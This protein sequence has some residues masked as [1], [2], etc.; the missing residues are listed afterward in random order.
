[1]S[2]ILII[3][4]VLKD[5]YLKLDDGPQ[6]DFETDE[7]GI[8][9]LDL[10]FNGAAHTFY[11]RTSVYGGAAVSLAT[12]SRLGVDAGILNS[13]T[14]FKNGELVWLDE[15]S[16]YR[17]IFCREGEI[18]YFVP[19]KRKMTDWSMP[20]GTPEWILVDRSTSISAKLVDE[21]KNFLKFSPETKLAVHAEKK[22]TPVG[23]RLADM[24]DVLF[25]ED[26]PAVHTEEKIVD[27]VELDQPNTQLVC[28]ISPRKI[29]LGEAEESWN[30]SRTDMLT[31][32]TVYSTI[33]ATVLG[34][35]S[36]GGSPENAVLWARLN[37]EQSTLEG[38][39]TAR[40]LKELAKAELEK[41]TN[42]KLIAQSIMERGRGVLAADQSSKTL[43]ERMLKAG[44]A[45]TAEKRRAFMEILLTTP[46]LKDYASGVIIS[47]EVAKQKTSQGRSFLEHLVYRGLIPGIKV[48]LGLVKLS[49]TGET[50]TL[51]LNGLAERLRNYYD[52][53]FRFAK[54]RAKFEITKDWP[55]FIAINKNAEQ[56]A[57]FA[58]E[59]QLA[60]LVPVVESDIVMD[61]DFTI[62]RGVEVCD[63]VLNSIFA[64]LGERRVD[65][66]GCI[67]KTNMV[68]SGKDAVVPANANEIGI[69]TAAVLRHAT[70]K[71]LAGVLLLSGGQDPKTAT[72]NL[73]AVCQNGPFPWPV[74]FAFGRA[75]QDPVLLT[76]KG[77]PENVKAAQAALKRHLQDNADALRYLRK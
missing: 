18:T 22:M 31:H 49:E 2:K 76:W 68:T 47:D 4:N 34:V 73:V 5:V 26:E 12:L 1:M 17:Y 20:N 52:R 43:S 72:K 65:L 19:G 66:G 64:R 15:P 44:V 63:R 42:L 29:S 27:K 59:C 61:G 40:R 6:N 33:V 45:A 21:I 28:H 38:T 54:W 51:G 10:A 35:L 69:A 60:G 25:L 70:P 7:N 62:E 46:E 67:L 77:K 48:D 53:G 32:L 39:L 71:Y 11:H 8:K 41:R 57:S 14:E 23:Q 13:K 36:V 74:T 3:G 24:A 55:T 37:A 16:D 58:K 30:L 9:W 50:Q 75:L 56:L